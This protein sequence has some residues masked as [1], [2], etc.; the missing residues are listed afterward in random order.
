MHRFEAWRPGHGAPGIVAQLPVRADH[1]L[2]ELA[3]HVL[4][5]LI[6][7]HLSNGSLLSY[8]MPQ[9]DCS[10]AAA[11]C[12]VKCR[13][14]WPWA[15][16]QLRRQSLKSGACCCCRIGSCSGSRLPQRQDESPPLQLHLG[17][18]AC[19]L[20]RSPTLGLTRLL[21]QQSIVGLQ[22]QPVRKCL[23][24]QRPIEHGHCRQPQP[25]Q[26]GRPLFRL[27]SLTKDVS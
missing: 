6:V 15:L 8:D 19:R 7:A 14:G 25:V 1:A 16:E 27:L 11:A 17:G 21:C 24:R 12:L 18:P 9:L 20:V 13:A 22:A 26:S 4:L 10:V 3:L 23:P 5:N 2:L